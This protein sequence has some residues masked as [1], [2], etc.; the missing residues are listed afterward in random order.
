VPLRFFIVPGNLKHLRVVLGVHVNVLVPSITQLPIYP[1]D[2]LTQLLVT[3][4][5]V[6]PSDGWGGLARL[7]WQ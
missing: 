3:P 5:A 4:A 6:F 2:S 7:A 1:I